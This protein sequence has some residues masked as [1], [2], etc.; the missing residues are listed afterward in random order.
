[1]TYI[2]P[3][4]NNT[5][6]LG[7]GYTYTLISIATKIYNVEC[8]FYLTSCQQFLFKFFDLTTILSG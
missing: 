2:Y 5:V 7:R 4:F 6:L 1:M 3:L 8:L